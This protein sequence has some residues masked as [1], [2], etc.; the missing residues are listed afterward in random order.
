MVPQDAKTGRREK[1]GRIERREQ[2]SEDKAS[3]K[4]TKS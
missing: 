4:Y 2:R 3:I 1:K